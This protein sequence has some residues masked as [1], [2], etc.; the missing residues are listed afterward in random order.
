MVR[1]LD[2]TDLLPSKLT[3]TLVPGLWRNVSIQPED[4]HM[5]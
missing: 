3:C 5:E 2:D 4:A 1:D